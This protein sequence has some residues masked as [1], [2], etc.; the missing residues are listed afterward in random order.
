MR[1]L[2]FFIAAAILFASCGNSTPADKPVSTLSKKD[3]EAFALRLDSNMNA[4]IST[5]FAECI[6]FPGL[7]E[8]IAAQ[9]KTKATHDVSMLKE[10]D[11]GFRQG[12][13]EIGIQLTNSI[14]NGGSYKLLRV[15]RKDSAYHALY[16]MSSMSGLNYHDLTLAEVKGK[17]MINDMFIYLTGENISTTLGRLIDKGVTGKTGNFDESY[18]SEMQSVQEARVLMMQGLYEEAYSI[19]DGLPDR[20]RNDKSAQV[21]KLTIAVQMSDEVYLRTLKEFEAKYPG[22]PSLSLILIEGF[23]M[24]EEY[25]KALLSINKLDSSVKDPYLDAYRANIYY[26]MEDVEKAEAYML[27]AV[28][29]V[30]DADVAVYVALAAIYLE[31]SKYED[32]IGVLRKLETGFKLKKEEVADLFADYEAFTSSPEFEKWLT[33]NG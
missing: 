5:F 8:S 25:G 24:K 26:L 9:R 31:Q 3:Y 27:K 32:T 16:R 19:I 13:E 33:E 29:N 15:Y 4:G 20:L 10:F 22:D 12:I 18:A 23:L 11:T 1:S 21:L 2:F 14:G 6:N 7:M 28:S 30:K 17:V